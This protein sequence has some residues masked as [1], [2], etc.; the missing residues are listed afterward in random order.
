MVVG[1]GFGAD[2]VQRRSFH[3][4]VDLAGGGPATEMGRRLPWHRSCGGGVE[5]GNGCFKL[6]LQ[7][8]HKLPRLPSWF[9]GG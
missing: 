5:G 6:T 3:G 1:S 7:R 4:G 8:L 2:C 9:L